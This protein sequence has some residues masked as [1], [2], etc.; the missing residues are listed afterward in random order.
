MNNG[1]RRPEQE[2]SIKTSIAQ[3]QKTC[4]TKAYVEAL[5]NDLPYLHEE[6]IVSLGFFDQ[7]FHLPG[8]HNKGFLTQHVC[9]C[10]KEQETN[11]P[12]LCMQ[13][14]QVQLSAMTQVFHFYCS[15][16]STKASF[17][18]FFFFACEARLVPFQKLT[19]VWANG[20]FLTSAVSVSLLNRSHAQCFSIQ[21]LLSGQLEQKVS[22][23]RMKLSTLCYNDKILSLFFY[24]VHDDTCKAESSLWPC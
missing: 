8:V 15:N 7:V 22:S 14:P 24:G 2:Q 19:N 1:T 18:K 16:S 3:H 17:F 9:P 21:W 20:Q 23:V 11:S 6:D 4:P 10:L 5:T 13:H 12:V